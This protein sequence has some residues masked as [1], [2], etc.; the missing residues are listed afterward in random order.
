V[1]GAPA[2]GAEWCVV[3]EVPT[4]TRTIPPPVYPAETRHKYVPI[5]SSPTSLLAEVS[6]GY[7]GAR[8]VLGASLS[9]RP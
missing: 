7:T 5:G 4:R 6:A 8:L 2:P 1:R 9:G 3:V